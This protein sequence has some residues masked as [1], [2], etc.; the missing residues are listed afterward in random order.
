MCKKFMYLIF[1]V[2]FAFST[3]AKAD[4]AISTQANWWSQG[5]ADSEMQEIVD[6]VTAVSVERFTSA[7]Q[8]ALATWVTAHTGNGAAD[9]LILCG[10][11]PD[12]IY[13][14]GNTQPDGSI[15][16]LFLDDGN[17]IINTGDYMFYVVNSTGANAEGGLQNMM[18]IAGITMWDD[19]TAVTVTAD[20]AL[21]TPTLAN[22]LT[23]RPFN[24]TQLS[25]NWVSEL[26]LAQN[27]G[28]TRADP[29]IVH[30]TVT[31][32]RL[33][34]FFQTA[35]QD[36]DPRGE[37]ISEWI[38]NWYIPFIAISPLAGSPDPGNGAI[39]VPVDANIGWSRGD[40][41][42]SDQVYFGTDPGNLPLVANLLTIFPAEY[43]PP[44]DLV[45][46]TT[47]SWQIVEVND[48]VLYPG[49]IWEF[50]TI[51]GEAAPDYPANGAIIAGDPYPPPPS[52]P[53]HI[54][55]P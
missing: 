29:I 4:I 19:N 43:N 18:D 39:D 51:R 15:A 26:V 31:D 50:T 9:L 5:A 28:G 35:S 48:A 3:M 27:A 8:A 6:N 7:Q 45:A 17:V 32:G 54:Y 16:E 25:N 11:F 52:I 42:D 55:T 49:A 23:D 40:G 12:T 2:A 33:G 13:P 24:V 53:T 38:N 1:F 44:G 22:F 46:S 20:G 34:I 37:V 10:Q 21:Y 36:A 47:Y 14:A 41:A 30:N